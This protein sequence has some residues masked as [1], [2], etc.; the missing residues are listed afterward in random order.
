[1]EDSLNMKQLPF[2]DEIY[3]SSFIGPL[4][5]PTKRKEKDADASDDAQKLESPQES[6]SQ[7]P[8]IPKPQQ[9]TRSKS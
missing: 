1:M 5:N 2:D 4:L 6:Q 3:Q 9:G 8:T 7:R